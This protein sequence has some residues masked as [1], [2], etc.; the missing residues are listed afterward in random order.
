MLKVSGP[1]QTPHD[2]DGTS[3]EG[4]QLAFRRAPEQQPLGDVVLN[5]FAVGFQLEI[6]AVAHAPLLLVG[7]RILLALP[8]IGLA[9]RPLGGFHR[10]EEADGPEL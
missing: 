3:R 7:V 8:P 5:F 10:I 9:G 6:F 1:A 2:H 4:H